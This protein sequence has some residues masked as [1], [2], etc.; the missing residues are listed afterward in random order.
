M[1]KLR[2]FLIPILVILTL[3]FFTGCH[4]EHSALRG[5]NGTTA[6]KPASPDI[7]KTLLQGNFQ[8]EALKKAVLNYDNVLINALRNFNTEQLLSVATP[9]RHSADDAY[10]QGNKKKGIRINAKLLQSNFQAGGKNGNK[11]HIEVVEVWGI[12][13]VDL[14]TGKVISNGEEYNYVKYGLIKNEAK[15][16]VQTVDLTV[17]EPET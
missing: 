13:K 9:D 15:W 3:L 5:S 12:E 7:N 16:L 1:K 6:N 8:D 11:A 2:H 10:I 4:N 17:Y 14:K